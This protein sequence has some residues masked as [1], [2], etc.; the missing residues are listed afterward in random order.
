MQP[1]SP[2]LRSPEALLEEVKWLRRLAQSLVGDSQQAEDLAQNTWLRALEHRPKADRPLRAWL[3]TV[4]TNLWRQEHRSRSRRSSREATATSAESDTSESPA[5]SLARVSLHQ[6]LAEAVLALEEPYRATVLLRYFD[7]LAPKD[8]ASRQKLPI[9]TVKTR[10][11]RGLDRLR[12]RLDDAHEG[13]GRAWVLSL[14]PNLSD[15]MSA[16]PLT[17][18]PTLS[19]GTLAMNLKVVLVALAATVVG[20]GLYLTR[21]SDTV[22]PTDALVQES[23]AAEEQRPTSTNQLPGESSTASVGTREVETMDPV[24]VDEESEVTTAVEIDTRVARGKVVD[25]SGRPVSGVKIIQLE[26]NGTQGMQD[27]SE[28]REALGLTREDGSFEVQIVSGG[29]FAVRDPRFVTVMT[30]SPVREGSQRVTV[31]VVAARISLAGLVLD[32]LGQPVAGA[33]LGLRPGE[34]MRSSLEE[35]LDDSLAV[36]FHAETDEEGRFE[37]AQAPVLPG[38]QLVAQATGF[39]S[40]TILAPAVS[41]SNLLLSLGRP[42]VAAEFLT[43]VVLDP[44]GM[45]VPDAMVSIGIETTHSDAQGEFRF[46]LSDPESFNVLVSGFMPDFKT[47]QLQ[48]VK[49]GHL[50]GT[51][52]AERFD[53]DGRPLWPEHVTLRLGGEPLSLEGRVVDQEG[54]GLGDIQVWIENPTLLGGVPIEG[55]SF[56]R[57]THVESTLGGMGDD[58]AFVRT[59]DEGKFRLNGLLDRDYNVEAM[60]PE[61][62]LRVRRSG[63]RPGGKAVEIQLSKEDSWAVVRGQVLD[64]Q[65]EPVGL[66]TVRLSC[67]AFITRIQGQV[68]GTRH[69]SG[70]QLR[71]DEEGRFEFRTIPKRLAYFRVDHPETIPQSFGRREQG[72]IEIV[73][74]DVENVTLTVSRRCH[75]RV[76]LSD[77]EQADEIVILDPEERPMTISEFNSQGRRDGD[78]FAIDDGQSNLWAVGEE[79]AT[80]VLFKEGEEVLRMPIQLSAQEQTLLEP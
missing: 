49:R 74:E 4:M 51:L 18:F 79:A 43:G 29:S 55:R 59:D 6:E 58:W 54:N 16:A 5:D 21:D 52:T 7:E 34:S 50:P 25:T 31:V 77:P 66:A 24:V 78:R 65:G 36:P 56:P 45:P 80:L 13:R 39:E 8:I 2:D 3:T 57:I 72:L 14:L 68:I 32:D 48:A 9:S 35:V 38:G 61:S 71:T 41:Q 22:A 28:S 10:L 73:G 20:T 1:L 69:A 23:H 63:I 60:D 19:I 30:G 44:Q 12:K 33:A 70:Q 42:G 67:D 47:D 53:S 62:L 64:R 26:G 27:E 40:T 75:F 17:Q 15:S 46:E 37:F 76:Q 11:S